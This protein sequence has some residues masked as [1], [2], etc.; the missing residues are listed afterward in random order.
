M[1][2]H[3][4][5][6]T[7]E[8]SAHCAEYLPYFMPRETGR[9]EVYRSIPTPPAEDPGTAPPWQADSDLVQ[10]AEGQ[11]P[12][13]LTRS[14]EYGVHIIHAMET[15]HVYRMNLNVMNTGGLIENLPREDCVEVPCTVDRLG[16]HPHHIGALPR[17][18]ASLCSHM[19]DVQT[20]ASDAF[21][22]K[23]LNKAFMACALDPCTAA[24]A[25]PSQI[26][27]CFEKLLRAERKWLEPY[28]GDALPKN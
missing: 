3:F 26:R 24:S 17:Q 6:W 28:W 7:T 10:Q 9:S 15:D 14:F 27:E 22:E 4:G 12:L 5:Y 1:L 16:V 11:K 25:T 19:S 18:L 2:K 8:S 21:L 13:Y 20:L 23:D